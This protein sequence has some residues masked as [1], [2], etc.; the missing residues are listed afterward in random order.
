MQGI[1]PGAKTRITPQNLY[2]PPMNPITAK[3]PDFE[4]MLGT[5]VA[6]PS[7]SC[8]DPAIDQSNLGVIHHLAGWLEDLGFTVEDTPLPGNPN[9]GNLIARIGPDEDGLVLAGHTDTVPYDDGAWQ[10]DPFALSD[11]DDAYYG[12]GTCDMKGFFPL[13]IEAVQQLDLKKLTRGLAV[14]ATA[15]EESS[16][17]GARLLTES[18]APKARYAIVGEPTGLT[19]VYAHK[20]IAMLSLRLEGHTGHSSDPSLGCN[21]L[22]AM[23]IL[24]GEL[25]TLREAL[26]QRHR[27]PGFAVQVPT[28]NLGC[29]HA[30]DNPNR[31][32]GSAE[33]Q[34]D[35]RLLPGMDSE[36][37]LEQVR[38]TALAVAERTGTRAQ[39]NAFYPPVPPFEGAPEGALIRTLKDVTGTA[40]ETVAFGTEAPFYQALGMETVVFGAGGIDQAHQPNEYLHKGQ[41]E[42]GKSAL[43]YCINAFCMGASS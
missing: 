38:K 11:R 6:T 13:V 8:T 2:N 16:M 15:D 34:I 3:L 30:G 37:V 19:P 20:G 33:L 35:L 21:A 31:I 1:G 12:L 17:A 32:C 42:T 36:A 43:T 23:H 22:D 28:M 4:A 24:M 29:L 9:K 18:G 14:I 40:P 25:I 41:I 26:A 10:S 27:H 39:V 7:V 5:L